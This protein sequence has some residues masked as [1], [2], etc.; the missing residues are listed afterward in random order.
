MLRISESEEY[1]AKL[2]GAWQTM[3][4]PIK[5][6]TSEWVRHYADTTE[7]LLYVCKCV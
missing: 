1:P 3:I 5:D 4:G 2:V 7:T 6:Q